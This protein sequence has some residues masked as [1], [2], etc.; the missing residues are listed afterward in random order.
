MALDSNFLRDEV[1]DLFEEIPCDSSVSQTWCMGVCV[2]GG[3]GLRRGWRV[4]LDSNFLRDEVEDLFEEI[5][6]DSSVS[7]TW[8]MGVCVCVCGGGGG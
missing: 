3:G 6:C 8:C 2:G 5:P 1:E 7:Q 4:A